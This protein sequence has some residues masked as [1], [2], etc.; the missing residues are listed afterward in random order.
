MASMVQLYGG[1]LDG[2]VLDLSA[3]SREE[4]KT[5]VALPAERCAYPGGRA[6]YTPDPELEG[7]WR[8]S[9]DIP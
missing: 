2:E 7:V 8:W 3:L 9:G 4:A 5:G 6:L 1:P